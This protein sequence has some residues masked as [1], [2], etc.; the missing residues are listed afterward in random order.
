MMMAVVYALEPH[1]SVAE[2]KAILLA[3]TLAERRPVH[4]DV[5][6]DTMLRKADIVVTAR[7]HG[8]LVGVAR[9]ITDYSF[10][11]YLS[12]L[13]VAVDFQK[14]G[15]GKQLIVETHKA[16]G[17]QAGLYLIAAPAA[18]TYYPKIGLQ[19]YPCFGVPRKI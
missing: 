15:I 19:S 9:A 14:Q 18:L 5:R 2:F 8:Q 16:A 3:S 10:C 7:V 11:C 12:D 17:E 1:L 13:A 6:L 4:D